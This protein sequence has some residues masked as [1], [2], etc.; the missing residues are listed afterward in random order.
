MCYQDEETDNNKKIQQ[1][2]D[3]TGSQDNLGHEEVISGQY[4]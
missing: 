4:E 2:K 1:N 3:F